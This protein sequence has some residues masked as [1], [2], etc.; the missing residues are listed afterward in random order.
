MEEEKR[1]E[2]RWKEGGKRNSFDPVLQLEE[3]ISFPPPQ[4]T[5]WK[6]P[7]IVH[8]RSDL[9]S[10]GLVREVALPC[11]PPLSTLHRI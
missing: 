6:T 11:L 3:R 7:L 9:V 10:C 2:G 1:D 5:L 8:H 4:K